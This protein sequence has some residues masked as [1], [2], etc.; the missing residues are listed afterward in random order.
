MVRSLV[1]SLVASDARIPGTAGCFKRDALRAE[2]ALPGNILI[3]RKG[4]HKGGH[5]HAHATQTNRSR[6]LMVTSK[7]FGKS[8]LGSFGILRLD[9]EGA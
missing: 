7:V 9:T 6:T 3:I 2:G 1:V 5:G 8:T 4:A